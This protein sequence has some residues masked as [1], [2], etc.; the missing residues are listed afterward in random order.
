MREPL[1]RWITCRACSTPLLIPRRARIPPVFRARCGACEHVDD[2][3]R[4]EVFE[5]P[6]RTQ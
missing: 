6:M 2:Y 3:T 5:R 4:T 1:E